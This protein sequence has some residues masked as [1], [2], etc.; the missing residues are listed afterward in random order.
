MT[1]S[2]PRPGRQ[3]DSVH[4]TQ[5]QWADREAGPEITAAR[6]AIPDRTVTAALAAYESLPPGTGL[7]ERMRYAIYM[8]SAI[9]KTHPAGITP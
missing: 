7:T 1:R 2:A 6:A 9:R 3:P 4:I 5:Q 8:V